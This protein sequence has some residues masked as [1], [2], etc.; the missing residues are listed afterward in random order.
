MNDKTQIDDGLFSRRFSPIS[1]RLKLFHYSNFSWVNDFSS[2]FCQSNKLNTHISLFFPK[3]LKKSLINIHERI[4]NKQEG[5][6]SS[7]IEMIRNEDKIELIVKLDDQ[8]NPFN[9]KNLYLDEHC[10]MKDI[11]M[12][13]N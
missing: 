1:H 2:C 10:L 11:R 13:F 12:I 8:I 4:I 3:Q 6:P 5:K 9:S 7:A